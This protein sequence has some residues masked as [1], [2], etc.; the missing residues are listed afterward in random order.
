MYTQWRKCSEITNYAWAREMAEIEVTG[1]QI[2]LELPL[3]VP[4][5]TLRVRGTDVRGVRVDGQDLQ[6]AVSRAAF[7][8]GTFYRQQDTTLLA[9]TPTQRQTN[10]EILA[11]GAS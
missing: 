7:Q 3:C 6:Q 11:E 9:F 8:N 2:R 10:V 1:S 5:L 4:E